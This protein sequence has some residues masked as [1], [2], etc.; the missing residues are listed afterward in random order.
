MTE[1]DHHGPEP[2]RLGLPTML[3]PKVTGATTIAL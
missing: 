2:M 1:F 3:A